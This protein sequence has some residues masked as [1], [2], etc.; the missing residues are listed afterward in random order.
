MMGWGNVLQFYYFIKHSDIFIRRKMYLRNNL[1]H[2]FLITTPY[3][4]DY[5]DD[6]T[7]LYDFWWYDLMMTPNEM[8]TRK[9]TN[10]LL[11]DL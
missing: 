1:E 2:V 10:T 7:F 11:D 8:I 5:G 9:M 3:D 4:G 6:T